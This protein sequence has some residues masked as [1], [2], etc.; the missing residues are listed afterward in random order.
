MADHPISQ[1]TAK[2]FS[3]VDLVAAALAGRLRIPEFQRP[4][5]W[6]WKDVSRLFDSIVKGYPIGNL[7]LWT[8][9]APAAEIRLGALRIRAQG[10]QDGW[11]VVDGQ[12]RLTRTGNGSARP[13][14]PRSA[15]SGP[16]L[17]AREP[18]PV[19]MSGGEASLPTPEN[20]QASLP[21]GVSRLP[22]SGSSSPCWP[23]GIGWSFRPSA[24]GGTGS[25]NYLIPVFRISPTTNGR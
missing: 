20:G 1:P 5:R 14:R 17:P 18:V 8:R 12:Q 24:T 4:L 6:Q 15:W 16:A 11:W 25:S 19:D 9:P 7:L 10:F 3:V 13:G 22:A 21:P 2:T 23:E